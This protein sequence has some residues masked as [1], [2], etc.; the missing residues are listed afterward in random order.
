MSQKKSP[1]R[2][3]ERRGLLQAIVK[4]LGAVPSQRD[5]RAH[6]A[7]RGHTVSQQMV[8]RDYQALG[9]RSDAQ[10]GKKPAGH[11]ARRSQ[12]RTTPRKR[13]PTPSPS[14]PSRPRGRPPKP[15]GTRIQDTHVRL[16]VW[17]SAETFAELEAQRDK[18]GTPFSRLLE[19]AFRARRKR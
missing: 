17:L 16:T 6:L 19:D 3:R 8:T 18:T 2:A 11:V 14:K 9:L 10:P 13:K 5:M 7:E 15:V 12:V 4:E 1:E